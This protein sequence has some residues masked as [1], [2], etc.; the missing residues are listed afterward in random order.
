MDPLGLCVTRNLRRDDINWTKLAAGAAI[1]SVGVAVMVGGTVLTYAMLVGEHALA[2]PTLG[3]SFGM[4]VHTLATGTTIIV[5]GVNITRV[6]V[7]TIRD[8]LSER[9][10]VANS[11]TDLC[12][13]PWT[14]GQPTGSFEGKP[15]AEWLPSPSEAPFVDIV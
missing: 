8:A 12:C 15:P 4:A 5:T 10:H 1:T 2:V 3:I 13:P 9:R 6:G 7:G 14:E 11:K